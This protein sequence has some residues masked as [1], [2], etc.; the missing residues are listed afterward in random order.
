MK[1]AV[2]KSLILLACAA[3][4]GAALAHPGH[5]HGPALLAGYLHPFGGVDHLLLML[6]VGAW[7][8]LLSRR[9]MGPA[10]SLPAMVL[11]VMAGAAGAGLPGLEILLAGSLVVM[12]LVLAGVLRAAPAIAGSLVIA[13]AA[14]HGYAHGAE[15]SPG[16]SVWLYSLGLTLAS[17]T[18][19]LAGM[20]LGRL[21]QKH[22][23]RRQGLLGLPLA[24]AGMW[25]LVM[26]A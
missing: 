2:L 25:L 26:G 11:G 6:G 12:G 9:W 5:A 24:A 10:A 14:L 3:L 17:L 15:M 8:A 4:P 1:K 13:M 7:A 21:A 23:G 18:L 20:G 22:M 19:Q 16:V